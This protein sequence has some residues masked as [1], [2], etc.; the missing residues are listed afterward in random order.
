MI[1]Q[2]QQQLRIRSAFARYRT[3]EIRLD[4]GSKGGDLGSSPPKSGDGC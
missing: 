1:K 4:Y 2:Q 3:D